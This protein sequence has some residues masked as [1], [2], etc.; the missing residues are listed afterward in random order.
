MPPP[1]SSPPSSTPSAMALRSQ[2]K[3]S[4]TSSSA[5]PQGPHP[6]SAAAS[7]VPISSVTRA[8]KGAK[9][10]ASAVHAS[11][12]DDDHVQ[13]PVF[14]ELFGDSEAKGKQSEGPVENADRELVSALDH[15]E[16]AVVREAQGNL[17]DSLNLYRKA[18]RM[19][20]RV[21]QTYRKK[22]FSAPASRPPQSSAPAGPQGPGP[23]KALPQ[24]SQQPRFIPVHQRPDHRLQNLAIVRSSAIQGTPAP[25]C[26]ISDLPEELLVH[27]FRDVAIVDVADFARLSRV[28]KRFAYLVATEERIWRRVCLGTEFGFAGMHYQFQTDVYWDPLPPTH[29]DDDDEPWTTS[30]DTPPPDGAPLDGTPLWLSPEE[31]AERAARRKQ[32]TTLALLPAFYASSWKQMWRNR[33][34]IRFN[35]CYIAT[36]NYI[37]S[38]IANANHI[39]WNSPVHIVTYYRYLR[40]F[41]DGTVISV[42]TTA[43]PVE[44]VP[45]LTKELMATHRGGA[46][47][48]L[49]S[50]VMQHALP[51]RWKLVS[52]SE[53]APE[54]S[55]PV[56]TTAA[57][58]A[59]AADQNPEGDL[60]IETEGVVGSKYIYRMDL[61][62][63]SAGKAAA[64]NNKLM[65]R[66]FY[67]Y[68]KLTDDWAK[69]EL[70]NYQPFFFSRVKSYGLGA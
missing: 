62:L 48:H 40:F 2:S 50:I 51:G 14:D 19:D 36:V 41:R 46:A 28:C 32:Q 3:R 18:F 52:A 64:R 34:R 30:G 20:S 70:K 8:P 35:G 9:A 27:I 10:P 59:A 57:A 47:P 16:A 7:S 43:E 37:R 22:H 63:R 4:T 69:F 24:S 67:S 33:P 42:L 60:V 5:H 39:T 23:P 31:R 13:P 1:P 58:A 26:P 54:S 17:G 6:T 15:F 44:V 25:P 55:E 21:D 66:G 11:Q 49:P 45:Y 29:L 61:S 12:A 38:G 56:G 53:S 68:N 65:W